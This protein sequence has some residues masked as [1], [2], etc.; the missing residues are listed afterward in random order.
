MR[1]RKP[2]QVRYTSEVQNFSM[3]KVLHSLTADSPLWESEK[4]PVYY[5]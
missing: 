4:V 3:E 2:Y 5:E 1:V